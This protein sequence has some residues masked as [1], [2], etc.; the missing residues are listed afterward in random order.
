M[1]KQQVLRHYFGH[2][3]F[4]AG[5]EK[6]VDALLN[7]RDALGVMPTGAGKSVCYQVP[8]LMLPGITLVISPLISL[9][10]DQVA[11]L[12][13]AGVPAAYINRSLNGAQMQAVYRNL[14]AGRYK[15]VYVSPERLDFPGFGNV[16]FALHIAKLLCLVV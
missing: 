10:A 15:I 5:Q 11:A 1:D 16:V 9:M 3:G 13:S 6:M 12:R 14:L 7:G 4:R 8:A 2:D